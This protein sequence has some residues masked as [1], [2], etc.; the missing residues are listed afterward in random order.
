M[1]TLYVVKTRLEIVI[2]D[3]K[4]CERKYNESMQKNNL[5]LCNWLDGR[6]IELKSEISFL[7][8]V[9]TL[10]GEGYIN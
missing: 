10:I 1:N 2:K 5:Q 3:L 9:I 7:N 8:M 4:E 6:M